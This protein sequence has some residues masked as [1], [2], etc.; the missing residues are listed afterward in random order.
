MIDFGAQ[1]G[2]ELFPDCVITL[3]GEL[4][5]GKTTL[6]KGIGQGLGV[7]KIISSPT[8]TIVKIYTGR[9]TLYHF[10]AYRLDKLSMMTCLEFI[11]VDP[12]ISPTQTSLRST[13]ILLMVSLK[14]E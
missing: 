13:F 7:R 9:L 3:N 2:S 10:D 12:V 4:G 1:L 6:T 11:S 14:K 8:F 5:A